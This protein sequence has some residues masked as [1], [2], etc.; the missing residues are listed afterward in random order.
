MAF[1]LDVPWGQAEWQR[2][3]VTHEHAALRHVFPVYLPPK[4]IPGEV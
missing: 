3:E 2:L 4:A 1:C